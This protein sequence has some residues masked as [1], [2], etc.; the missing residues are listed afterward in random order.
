MTDHGPR[1]NEREFVPVPGPNLHRLPVTSDADLAARAAEGDRGA[2]EALLRRHYDGMHRIAWRMTGS[3]HD[4]EDITQE[5]CCALVG[6]IG[7]FKG[8]ARFTTWLF[9]IVV[10]ACR[11]HHRR[12]ATLSRLRD[13]LAVL[14]GLAAPQDGRDLFR[15]S[16]LAGQLARLDPPLRETIVLVVGEG[17]TH[18][19]AGLA[20]GLAETTISWRLH[21]ARRLL[22]DSLAKAGHDHHGL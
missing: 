14:V 1:C 2:L 9:G 17:L 13:G 15:R 5:V 12:R 18:A 11:D 7:G 6:R 19:E 4:A 8:E 22:K 10:N 16:W 21:E 3:R 20:L